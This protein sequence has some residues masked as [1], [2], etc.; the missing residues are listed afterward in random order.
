M[1]PDVVLPALRILGQAGYMEYIDER[2]NSSRIRILLTRE[3]LYNVGGLSENAERVLSKV[4]RLYPGIFIDYV[5]INERRVASELKFDEQTVYDSMLELSRVGVLSYVPRSRTPYIY[6]PTSRE[7][8]RY[9]MIGKAVYEDRFGMQ[10]RRIEAMID[11]AADG[12]SCRVERMLRY[13]GEPSARPC[14]TCDV[15][16]A[17]RGRKSELSDRELT[18]RVV[19]Y[20]RER[21]R[22][23]RY[24]AL[25]AHIGHRYF[26]R[27]ATLIAAWLQDGL[28]EMDGP[29]LRMIQND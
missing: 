9:V 28:A 23:V 7:E 20:L 22:G 26:G 21:P 2:E 6:I 8:P 11:Y 4:L 17:E 14:G 10:E 27:I 5:Y 1:S 16:R 29:Y 3:D 18:T 24:E 25:V 19:A 12:S 15:C 13:F